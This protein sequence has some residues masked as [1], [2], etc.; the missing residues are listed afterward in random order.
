MITSLTISGFRCFR[1]LRV[2]PLTRVNLIVGKNNAGKTSLLEAVELVATGTLEALVRSPL[3][4]REYLFDGLDEWK[5]RNRWDE[6]E[7]R[8]QTDPLLD[9]SQMFHGR[10]ISPGTS[11]SIQTKGVPEHHVQCDVFEL[12]NQAALHLRSSHL[13]EEAAVPL[14]KLRRSAA[15]NFRR[16]LTTPTQAVNL[17]ETEGLD[18]LRL[19]EPWDEIVLTSEE[20]TIL[21]ALQLIE[22]K[23]DRLAFAGEKTRLTRRA[24]LTLSGSNQRLP[25]GSLGDGL[26]ACELIG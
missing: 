16:F 17:L 21:E 25:L 19:S 4:R 13:Q 18:L 10:S 11:F 8:S 5:E 9:L 14:A 2:E 26:R 12:D 22:P 3:R 24:L 15:L 6:E 7:D 1:E 20:R 23:I